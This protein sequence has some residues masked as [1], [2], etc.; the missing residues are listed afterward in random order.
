M[1]ETRRVCVFTG[2]RAD[3]GLLRCLLEELRADPA[4][5]LQIVAAASHLSPEHGLTYRAIEADGFS[6]DASVDMLLVGSTRMS[7]AKSL[8]VGVL[9]LADAFDRLA[10]D[11]VVVLG[12]RYEAL[13]A[14]EVALVLGVPLAHVCGGEVTEGGAMDDSIRH[15]ITKLAQVHFVATEEFGR[16]VV[17]LGEDPRNVHVVGAPGLDNLARLPLFDRPGLEHELRLRLTR[18][19]LAVT[20]HPVTLAGNLPGDGVGAVLGGL[21]TLPDATVVVTMPNADPGA[22]PIAAA[23]DRWAAERRDRVRTFRSLGQ[24]HY[25]SLLRHADAVVG[26]SSSGLIEAPALGTPTVDVG[27]RQ[28]GRPRAVSVLHCDER[29]GDVAA[30]I[31]RVLDHSFRPRLDGVVSPYGRGGAARTMARVLVETPLDGIR[32][33][34]FHPYRQSDASTVTGG[35]G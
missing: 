20:Y 23:I 1:D 21:E 33:K 26:N 32:R 11:I 27:E 31:R 30:A 13:A 10:P 29:A 6:V 34:R 17:Q 28:A 8:G 35:P 2:T 25:L 15:A 16:R 5:R 3:Y 7:T 9:G 4:V 24:L 14:A 22:I 19:T 18:P 12:D